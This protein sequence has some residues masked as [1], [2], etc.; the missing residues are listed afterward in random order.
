MSPEAGTL[1]VYHDGT[2][3]AMGP[4]PEFTFDGT[5]PGDYWCTHEAVG[6]EVSG[7]SPIVHVP[8]PDAF[9]LLCVGV[10]LLYTIERWRN[11]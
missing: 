10:A 5:P 7:P 4:T 3:V 1:R 2:E 8:E 11:R 6:W 9:T